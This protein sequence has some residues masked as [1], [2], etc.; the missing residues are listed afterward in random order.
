MVVFSNDS[1]EEKCILA[2]ESFSREYLNLFLDES[3][4][5][6]LKQY[7]R[8]TMRIAS[9]YSFELG[10]IRASNSDEKEKFINLISE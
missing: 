9:N 2:V 3:F 4:D 10:K 5:K 8:E 7:T 1:N 6:T